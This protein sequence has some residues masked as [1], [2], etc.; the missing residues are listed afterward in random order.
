MKDWVI[1]DNFYMEKYTQV[2][3]GMHLKLD[4]TELWRMLSAFLRS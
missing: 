3:W 1:A 2:G 4:M